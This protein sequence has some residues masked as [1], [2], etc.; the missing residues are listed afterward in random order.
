MT[1]LKDPSP[2]VSVFM[3]KTNLDIV[4]L[5]LLGVLLY[6]GGVWEFR[7]LGVTGFLEFEWLRFMMLTGD[8]AFLGLMVLIILSG[9][10]R[11]YC[12]M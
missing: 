10:C 2:E 12:T 3:Y 9:T 7:R 1:Q 8:A 4:L 6:D 11:G 5:Y